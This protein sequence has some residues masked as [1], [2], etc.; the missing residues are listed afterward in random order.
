MRSFKSYLA[1]LVNPKLVPTALKVAISVG[2]MLFCINH[3]AALLRN[4][5]TPERWFAVGLTYLMPY[6]VN[7]HGQYVSSQRLR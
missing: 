4:E 2:S 1:C 3:G 5:M 7:I 6:L